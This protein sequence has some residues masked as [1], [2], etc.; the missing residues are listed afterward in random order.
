ETAVHEVLADVLE[1]RPL[2][3]AERIQGADDR[4]LTGPANEIHADAGLVERSKDADVCE[5]ARAA[6]AEH[7]AGRPAEQ[8]PGK[9][10]DIADDSATN[11]VVRVDCAVLQP[12]LG[13][14]RTIHRRLV[15]ERERAR[16]GDARTPE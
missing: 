8:V 4:A 10:L 3:V 9:A 5:A 7:D 16:R 2:V 1:H 11:V 6:A 15:D 14:R 13:A 12:T